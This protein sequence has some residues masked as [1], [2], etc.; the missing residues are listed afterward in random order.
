MSFLQNS[1]ISIIDKTK[2][3]SD[4]SITNNKLSKKKDTKK[5]SSP[6]IS[7]NLSKMVKLYFSPDKKFMSL[8]PIIP[9]SRFDILIK[10]YDL[11]NIGITQEK[12]EE[13]INSIIK[14]KKKK[15][16]KI[17]DEHFI[18][19]CIVLSEKVCFDNDINIVNK[20]SNFIFNYSVNFEYSKDRKICKLKI[21][22]KY[23]MESD[24]CSNENDAKK[25][26]LYKFIK[27]YIPSKESTKII[28]NLEES[29]KKEKQRKEQGKNKYIEYLNKNNG[30]RK[31]LKQKR[32]KPIEEFS[33]KL[34]YF[35]MLPK[36][37][38][39]LN[40][41]NLLLDDDNDENEIY[42]VNTQKIPVNEILLGDVG[43]VDHHLNDFK[44][45][46]LKLYEMIRD[47]E[48]S[49]SV[50]FNM[51]YSQLNSEDYNTNNKVTIIS[52]K[53]GISVHGYGKTKIEAENKCA[54]NCL[55]V[56]FKKKFKTFNELHEYFERKN[57]KYLDILLEETC[58]NNNINNNN[59]NN[60][61]KKKEEEYT[62]SLNSDE[63]DISNINDN[64]KYKNNIFSFN[65]NENLINN[66]I[67][68]INNSGY[69]SSS[70]NNSI[71]SKQ[72][73]EALSSQDDK[74]NELIQEKFDSSLF[75][76]EE[77]NKFKSN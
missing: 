72:L 13:E 42:F 41:N 23:L 33:Q 51:N 17:T 21:R 55:F 58:T 39:N 34:P 75:Y 67:S 61:K 71:S 44:Y 70:N 11:K 77:D 36:D 38:K 14:G 35:N 47:S 52:Q 26:V 16:K 19:D 73:V 9:I 27:K 18:K 24:I 29:T 28:K 65:F 48:K 8:C 37:K 57:G 43:I 32:K 69:S 50:D 22:E 20:I 74:I 5:K 49:R 3:E 68:E 63:S 6:Q 56:L 59:I 76:I 31:L 2:Q 64:S 53:L 4:N 30:D 10:L 46:P 54:L 45:T 25:N 62:I 60:N 1:S 12:A 7:I 66:G 15:N 40:D